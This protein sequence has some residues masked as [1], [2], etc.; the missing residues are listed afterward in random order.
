[1]KTP[2]LPVICGVALTAMSTAGLSHW[3]SVRQFVAAIDAGV[4]VSE[5]PRIA[6]PPSA[7]PAG[8]GSSACPRSPAIPSRKSQ[9]T[10]APP[11]KLTKRISTKR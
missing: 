4:P 11:R 2:T 10:S 6:V 7:A 1:M 8:H 3:W 9:G 5:L